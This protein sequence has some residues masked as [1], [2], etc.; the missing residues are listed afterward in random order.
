MGF[1]PDEER[2]VSPGDLGLLDEVQLCASATRTAQTRDEYRQ[3]Q[4]HFASFLAAHGHDLTTADKKH[5]ECFV[6]HLGAHD[7]PVVER[8]VEGCGSCKGRGARPQRASG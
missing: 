4:E 7:D 5:V 8:L 2:E 6:A 1:E 3:M